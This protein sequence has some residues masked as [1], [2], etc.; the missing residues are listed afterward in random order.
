MTTDPNQFKPDYAVPPGV[1]L[2]EVLDDQNMSQSDLAIRCGLTDKTISQIINVGAPI[3]VDTAEKFELVLGIPAS[4]WNR[5]ELAYREAITKAE[6]AAKLEADFAWLKEVPVKELIDR[7]YIEPTNDKAQLVRRTLQFFAV[8]SVAAWRQLV[9][10]PAMRF[11]GGAVHN[12]KPGYVA[13]WRRMGIIQARDIETQPFDAQEFRKVLKAIRRLT[14]ESSDV[15]QAEVVRL[16]A[17]AGVAVVFTKEIPGASVSGATR[18]LSKDKALIQLSLKYKSDDQLWFTFFHEAGHLL[19]HSKKQVFI[20]YAYNEDDEEEREANQ[21]ARDS[22]IPPSHVDR[23]PHIARS[24][25]QVVEF[26]KFLGVSPGVVVGRL[27]HDGLLYPSAFN[28]LK[29]KFVWRKCP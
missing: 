8:S 5:R 10:S 13:A 25:E 15:W 7:G 9:N 28:D 23:L 14:T 20:D 1:T 6:E 19:L 11:R 2:K 29:R 24:R 17:A 27:Q 16:C 3:T 22:L 26:A 18:W 21:F 4:F 12:R